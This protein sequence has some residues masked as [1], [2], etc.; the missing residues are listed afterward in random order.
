MRKNLTHHFTL[1]HDAIEQTLERKFGPTW[2]EVISHRA[3]YEYP[4]KAGLV[5][6]G[7][8]APREKCPTLSVPALS[9]R[10]YR[11]VTCHPR[12]I[13]VKDNLILPDSDRH[14]NSGRLFHHR[15]VPASAWFGRLEDFIDP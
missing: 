11:D 15:V 8:P 5:M 7:D 12:E 10:R 2:G 13:A 1:R 6:H 3:A 14:W 4:S 9:L